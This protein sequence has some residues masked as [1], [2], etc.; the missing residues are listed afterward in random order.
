MRL[1]GLCKT[2]ALNETN[3]YKIHAA[4]N[5]CPPAMFTTE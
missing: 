1:E 5:A 2:P 3:I 4:F